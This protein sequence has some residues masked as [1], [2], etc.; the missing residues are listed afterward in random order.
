VTLDDNAV[1]VSARNTLT[2]D[3]FERRLSK[4]EILKGLFE[5]SVPPTLN[6]L[7]G[8]QAALIDALKHDAKQ[9]ETPEGISAQTK[10]SAEK[11]TI[12][13]NF[14]MGSGYMAMSARATLQV[15]IKERA[16][17]DTRHTLALERIR[18]EMEREKEALAAELDAK[19][20]AELKEIREENATLKEL[21]HALVT[22]PQLSHLVQI[23]SYSHAHRAQVIGAHNH[24]SIVDN[25]ASRGLH[26]AL[27][28]LVDELDLSVKGTKVQCGDVDVPMPSCLHFAILNKD[29][30]GATYLLDRGANLEEA[31]P[32]AFDQGSRQSSQHCTPLQT[33]AKV[34]CLE[35][36]KLLIERGAI[37]HTSEF[38]VPN[39]HE[40]DLVAG[41]LQ[42][43]GTKP[44]TRV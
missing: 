38:S 8:F 22:L 36:V 1:T 33:A 34:A 39:G 16:S 10:Q 41:Y 3:M 12:T 13:V 19:L 30:K 20:H 4:E 5:G 18:K 32:I 25:A 31:R 2:G 6:T 44:V 21:V 23:G 37:T 42:Q 24:T 11:I 35:I 29:L 40:G 27:H 26:R 17:T 15:P 7:Q 28:H 43:H 14:Q 9:S